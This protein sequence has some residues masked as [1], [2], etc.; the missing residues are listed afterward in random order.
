METYT[1]YKSS[2]IAWLGDI[3]EH[4]SVKRIKYVFNFHDNQRI[5]LSTDERG[6]ML[7]KKY[8]YYGASG[9][10]DKVENYIFDGVFILFGE[11]GAN[12]L[13]RNSPLAFKASGRFWVN[14]HAHILSPKNMDI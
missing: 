11:D 6:K 4:W 5:P 8:D 7:V 3:P 1:N 14:N 9:V 13:A 2:G 10:I 12:L